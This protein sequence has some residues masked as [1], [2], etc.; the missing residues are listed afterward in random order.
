MQKKKHVVIP[1]YLPK[2]F[3]PLMM[4]QADVTPEELVVHF[5]G[6]AMDHGLD[7][8]QLYD[9]HVRFQAESAR[10]ISE[11]ANTEGIDPEIVAECR[12]AWAERQRRLEM[13]EEVRSASV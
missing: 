9:D 3:D 5:T 8:F 10:R 2:E 4:E 13:I 12:Q 1:K 7:P 6:Y 11:L